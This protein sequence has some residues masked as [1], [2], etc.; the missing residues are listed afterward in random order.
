VLPDGGDERALARE[1]AARAA[2]A[3]VVYLGEQHDN[4]VHHARQRL[5]LEAMAERGPAPAVGFEMLAATRQ[6]EVEAA[7]AR[8]PGREDLEAAL[9]WRASGWPAFAMYWPLFELALRERLPVLALD[10]DTALTRRVAREGLGALGDAAA[11]LRSLL[12]PDPGREAEIIRTIRDAHCGVVAE[13]R[14]RTMAEAWHARNVTMAR[15]IAAA[16]DRGRRVAVIVGRGHQAE[17]GLPA[18]LAALRP[19]TRQFVVEL[20]EA[21]PGASAPAEREPSTADVVW[22]GPP[23]ERPDPCAGRRRPAAGAPADGEGPPDVVTSGGDRRDCPAGERTC[24]SSS[25]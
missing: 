4:P 12:P 14:A 18:Q 1:I 22:I 13:A 16:L 19:G 20:V 25:R 11:E 15:R 8:A 21:R 5:V 9:G 7:L 3:E 2:G 23:V 6:A 24:G 10:L 17:G